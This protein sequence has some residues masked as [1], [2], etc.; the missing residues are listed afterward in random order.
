MIVL[1]AS[2]VVELL[3]RPERHPGLRRLVE[4]SEG[5][6]HAPALMDAEVSHTLRRL[7]ARGWLESSRGAASVAALAELP[8]R[9]YRHEPMLARMWSLRANLTAYDATYVALAE[10]LDCPLVTFDARIGNAAGHTAEVVV[11]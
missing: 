2:A 6:W 4:G 9:R 3:L 1:D 8:I 11:P 5:G 7:E 10:A